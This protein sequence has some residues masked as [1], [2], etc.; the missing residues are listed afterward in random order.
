MRPDAEVDPP[1][2]GLSVTNTLTGPGPRV[3]AQAKVSD[4]AAVAAAAAAQMAVVDIRAVRELVE[5]EAVS[6]LLTSIWRGAPNPPVT[7]EL[8]RAMS[9]AGSYV[10]GAFKGTAL[11]GACVGFFAAPAEGTMHSHIA[12]VSP[13]S[14]LHNVGFAMKLHQRAW[15]LRHGVSL[16]E[17]T[18][19]PLVSA[20]AYFNIA[21]LAGDP[22]QYLP[23]FYGGMGDAINGD[24][25]SD[26]ILLHWPLSDPKVVRACS[27]RLPPCDAVALRADGAVVALGSSPEGAPVA[28]NTRYAGGAAH[29]VAVPSDI[30]SMRATDPPL[31]RQ[32]R[33]ALRD[34]LL[35][36]TGDGLRITDFDKAG[37]YVLTSAAAGTL[38]PR[39]PRSQGPVVESQG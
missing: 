4:T 22:A 32:W 37:W 18:F 7:T 25:E 34:T 2:T 3:G 15:A 17:W 39:S 8:L 33:V 24:D 1:S 38:R 13:S 20:N 21:K 11:V 6:T 16:I 26:R 28:G 30:A 12:G 9:L 5:L 36:L 27:G 35:E 29:L 23:N 10:A 19:D 31:A 14:R